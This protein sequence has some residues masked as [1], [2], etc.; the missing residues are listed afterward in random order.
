M[1]IT[2]V[3]DDRIRLDGGGGPL[4]VEA[5]TAETSY[6]PYHMLASGLAT[7]TYSVLHSWATH[8]K[9]SAA[10]LAIEVGWSFVEGPHRVGEMNLLLDWPSLPAE[11]HAAAVR[12]A[13][14]CPVKKTLEHPPQL[15]TGVKT[16]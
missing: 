6:S 13:G 1:K 16:P 11:R 14:L 15:S 8:A 4:T 10:D 7:C 9:L 3:A 5:E 12:A 2:L